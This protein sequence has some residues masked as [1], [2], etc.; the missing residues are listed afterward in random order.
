M[1]FLQQQPWLLAL[2]IFF[3][4]ILDVSL[5]CV[6]TIQVIRGH[7][8]LAAFIGFFEIL[9]WIVAASQVI[10]NLDSWYLAVA[11]AAGFAA[12]NIAGIWLEE[13]LA[14]GSELV[15]VISANREVSLAKHLREEGFSVLELAGR[16][17]DR[18]P[19]EVLLVVEK[20]RRIPTLLRI[21]HAADPDAL[22]TITDVKRQTRPAALRFAKSLEVEARGGAFRSK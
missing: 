1:E 16:G 10:Q 8:F 2:G 17:D 21:I 15:R 5:G 7:R 3:A 9:V 13:R 20:R 22:W 19:V 6:R 11:Y 14:I 12:G 4:R 18:Q